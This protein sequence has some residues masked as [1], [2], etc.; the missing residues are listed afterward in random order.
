MKFN[1]DRPF[2][3]E[4]DFLEF[5]KS[6]LI[7]YDQIKDHEHKTELIY[8][9]H[10]YA[11]SRLD[12]GRLNKYV[13]ALFGRLEAYMHKGDLMVLVLAYIYRM[14]KLYFDEIRVFT[15]C[16]KEAK[17]VI[18]ELVIIALVET[19][20]SDL[21][22][23]LNNP[24]EVSKAIYKL[25]V[26]NGDYLRIYALKN[27]DLTEQYKIYLNKEKEDTQEQLAVMNFV[28]DA[29]EKNLNL[30]EQLLDPQQM[31]SVL[32]FTQYSPS[33]LV[34]AL[35]L[36]KKYDVEFQ[37]R[38]V[39]FS[40][41]EALMH[42]EDIKTYDLERFQNYLQ[43]VF[44]NHY[45]FTLSDDEAILLLHE[46]G[47]DFSR[48]MD[49]KLMFKLASLNIHNDENQI[50]LG[51]NG[52]PLEL[53][54][55]FNKKY[56][57]VKRIPNNA[58]EALIV[59]D[60]TSRVRFFHLRYAVESYFNY[61]EYVTIPYDNESLRENFQDIEPII[62]KIAYIM[63]QTLSPQKEAFYEKTKENFKATYLGDSKEVLQDRQDK[64]IEYIHAFK[65]ENAHIALSEDVLVSP[66]FVINDIFHVTNHMIGF[67][68]APLAVGLKVGIDKDYFIKNIPAFLDDIEKGSYKS[69]G[70][71]L[72]FY[73]HLK[74]FDEHSQHIIE[75]IYKYKGEYRFK[76]NLGVKIPP[77]HAKHI[78]E[79][80]KNRS[81][82]LYY[83]QNNIMSEGYVKVHVL[84]D[85]FHVNMTLDKNKIHCNLHDDLNEDVKLYDFEEFAFMM[86]Y[87]RF[88][89]RNVVFKSKKQFA[90]F[91]AME[92]MQDTKYLLEGTRFKNEVLPYM[93]EDINISKEAQT[94][95]D[96]KELTIH[97]YIDYQKEKNILNV[98]TKFLVD[99][100]EMNQVVEPL[101]LAKKN[102]Y[103]QALS[104]YR[105]NEV[106]NII[107]DQDVIFF[108]SADLSKLKEFANVYI[109][110]QLNQ[111]RIRKINKAKINITFSNGIITSHLESGDLDD[112]SLKKVLK[113]YKEGKK[114]VLLKDEVIL[115]DTKEVKAIYDYYEMTDQNMRLAK[116]VETMPLQNIFKMNFEEQNIEFD[117]DLHVKQVVEKIQRHQDVP[118]INNTYLKSLLKP[119]QIEGYQWLKTLY[120]HQLNGI[121]ADD[122]GLGKTIQMLSLIEEIETTNPILI[123][124]PK[125]LVYNW[126]AEVEKFRVKIETL[127]YHGNKDERSTVLN[128]IENANQKVI[129]ITSYQTLRND[130]DDFKK[131]K[132]HMII[133]DEAQMIK[134][135]DAQ[136]TIAVKKLESKHRYALTGTPIENSLQDLWSIFDFLMPGYLLSH[137]RFVKLEK[138]VNEDSQ[139]TIKFLID[140]TKLFILR[141]TKKIVLK[142]LPDKEE[143]ILYGKLETD[144]KK[145]YDAYLYQIKEKLENPETKKF[146]LL[147]DI[148]NLRMLSIDTKFLYDT[149][150]ESSK[151]SM[152]VELI[153]N[154][155]SSGH[156]ILVFSSFV[157]ALDALKILL[158]D[159]SYYEITGKTAAGLRVSLSNKFNDPIDETNVFLISLK[160]GG[161]GLNLIGAD[162]IIHL[163]PWWNVAAENQATDRAH[164]IGQNENVMVYK[165]IMK[166]T[167][168]EKV[169]KLQALK[170]DLFDKI[171]LE[172]DERSSALTLDDYK[173]LL[174]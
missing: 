49:G 26:A 103:F 100:V 152:V 42:L 17:P 45:N 149:K 160:A 147:K 106:G 51:N 81:L 99:D 89:V 108:L 19:R 167:I 88:E 8:K 105:F 57:H 94:F 131:L 127:I 34:V 111:M 21:L 11:K 79:H 3:N 107:K 75:A 2:L 113:A 104:D 69:Y 173:F 170:Q 43:I 39:K 132:F 68:D 125:S 164:R 25:S 165:V 154:A 28:E 90:L 96:L 14:K 78:F 18:T 58:Y 37:Y 7:Y 46:T 114:F 121:L 23:Y 16:V 50:Y 72:S 20:K 122:M 5:E 73:H 41:K 22:L 146:D 143:V 56:K 115:T 150:L 67:K 53:S 54:I 112:E 52:V 35:D 63:D 109:S 47:F 38:Y 48:V 153:T 15:R 4:N 139:A 70:K 142:E 65:E 134:T 66:I 59:F 156:K 55:L 163:D 133:L 30:L 110:D 62:G 13:F 6:F 135:K 82:Y 29:N 128:K 76:N 171:L 126:E 95:Y 116:K 162:M 93:L 137:Q 98:K 158:K 155:I 1:F 119:Y 32:T 44:K 64:V 166:D 33:K 117:M 84:E 74:N 172:D 174:S 40:Y 31:K 151:L 83:E 61:H 91:R 129:V 27:I 124:C 140:K 157:K 120:D 86:D 159:I 123:V 71:N 161:T 10:P 141:R 136:L 92:M 145:V 85:D 144:E 148:M 169:I 138:E 60:N 9:I 80:T 101:H 77:I 118:F 130:V 168:E 102:Q 24:T 87:K 12:V 97:A 36:K